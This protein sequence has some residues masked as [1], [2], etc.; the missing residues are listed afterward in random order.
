MHSSELLAAQA[1]PV[2]TL[3]TRGSSGLTHTLRGCLGRSLLLYHNSSA[4]YVNTS[5]QVC[6][7]ITTVG[8]ATST[9]WRVPAADSVEQPLRDCI[10]GANASCKGAQ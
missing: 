1:A 2:K 9:R 10:T 6:C 3:V 8:Q 5:A 4:G 7:C